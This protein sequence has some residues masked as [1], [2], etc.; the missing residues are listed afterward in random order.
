MRMVAALLVLLIGASDVEARGFRRRTARHAPSNALRRRVHISDLITEPGTFETEWYNTY[1]VTGGS[2]WMPTQLKFTPKG[3][4]W[5]WGNTEFAVGM[6]GVASEVNG[7]RATHF[8]D[9]LYLTATTVLHSG[10]HFSIAASPQVTALLRNDSG[11]RLG[12]Y[13]IARWDFGGT[14]IGL[15]G[16]WTGATASS[17]TNPAGTLDYGVGF[18]QKLSK[19]LP[20]TAHASLVRERSTGLGT[21]NSV[22]EGIAFDLRKNLT[23]DISAQHLGA[24]IGGV[25]HQ[26]QVGLIANFGAPRSWFRR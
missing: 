9:H 24:A 4:G 13:T 17:L 8:S 15:T 6:D 25:D 2:Y 1:S 21:F 7:D 18:G 23:L 14:N 20:I 5:F 16:S 22:Y 3:D 11:W 26:V 19:K 10:S 12:G